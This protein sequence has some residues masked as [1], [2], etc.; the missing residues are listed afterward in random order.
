LFGATSVPP[1][2]VTRV[3]AA[4][5]ANCQNGVVK[6]ATL[7]RL[8]RLSQVV[9]LL[10]FV[11]LLLQTEF[12]GSLRSSAAE[13]HL[14]Y[15]V[16]LFFELDPLVGISNA[17]ASRA[18]Y[19]GLLWCLLIVIPTLF[20]G[21]FFCGWVCPMGTLN[22][23]FGSLKS[24]TKLGKQLI[25]SNRYKRWQTTKYYILIGT[26]IAALL[27][28]GVVGW[29][30][31]FSLLTRSFSLSIL[32]AFNYVANVSLK[33]AENADSTVLRQVG[34]GLHAVLNAVVL[35]FKQPH[36]RQGLVI[37][38]LF[39][40][41]L[42]L[43]FR[44]S[45]FFCRALCPLGALLGVLSRW[46]ILGLQKHAVACDSCTRCLLRCQGGDDPI[47]GVPWRKA[48]CHLCLNCIG[49]CPN[50]GLEFRFFP[51]EQTVAVGP[52]LARRKTL[53]GLAAGVAVI[54]LLRSTTA[55][56]AEKDERL[57]RP[58]GSLEESDF[59]ARCV[60]CGECMKVCPNNALHPALSEAGLEG[61]WTPVVVP[62]VGY[63]EP[64]CVLCSEVCPTGAIWE[65][66]PKSKGW[67]VGMSNDTQPI[68]I[69]TAF[70]DRGR[71]LPWA[72]ASECIV[73][74]EW[75]PTSPKAIYLQPAEV[76]D[77]KGQAKILKQPR[78]DPERCV[79]CGA[80]EYACPVH[81]RP[82]VYVTSIG[83][84]RSK[85]NQIL[86]NQQRK[87]ARS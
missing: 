76:I 5:A 53:T 25:E 47:G 84:S 87:S 12:R 61:I 54:P 24:E 38:L 31:P 34:G 18:L 56:V 55:F 58:P 6:Y 7:R 45:R 30:D 4:L 33:A 81:D 44:V 32:P 41:I 52:N 64:S 69:G 46:S 59:L 37:G 63:C 17:L 57:L 70:Y 26:L 8:R 79:G 66:S 82:A 20:L 51:Q 48:E 73:C 21:R 74:E 42:V 50:Q 28:T 10:A 14:A 60:R 1:I 68:R 67:A 43:N 16:R 23:F 15:P 11:L 85:T 83:E 62:R 22:H 49:E 39:L 13:I 35:S 75:C 65:T 9:F 40:F 71:C 19:R 27:G 86:L 78:V 77:A 36:F 29:L 72:M 80:C 3:T 2:R